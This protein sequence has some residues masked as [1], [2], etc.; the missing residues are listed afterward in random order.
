MQGA[1]ANFGIS[2]DQI[3][4]VINPQPVA[5]PQQSYSAPQIQQAYQDS[6]AQ[7]YTP[8]QISYG[9]QQNFGISPEQYQT[10]LSQPAISAAPANPYAFYDA[11]IKTD[12]GYR[13]SDLYGLE[14][15]PDQQRILGLSRFDPTTGQRQTTDAFYAGD[16]LRGLQQ[17]GLGL[18][19]LQGLNRSLDQTGLNYRP[20]QQYGA[21]GS[22]HGIDFDA[23]ARGQLGTAY[24]WTSDV[25]VGAKGPSALAQLQRDQQIAQQFG[26]QG[27]N[28]GLVGRTDIPQFDTRTL[29]GGV[30][31]VTNVN[32]GRLGIDPSAYIGQLGGGLSN[33]NPAWNGAQGLTTYGQP[34]ALPS[35]MRNSN[36][37][38]SNAQAVQGLLSD[39]KRNVSPQVSQTQQP[40]QSAQN[41]AFNLTDAQKSALAELGPSQ[42]YDQR[43]LQIA[44]LT[45]APAFDPSKASVRNVQ[46]SPPNN[47]TEGGSETL[48][49]PA[50]YSQT[51]KVGN[52]EFYAA[53]DQNG[54]LLGAAPRDSAGGGLKG[55]FTNILDT[56]GPAAQ[57]ALAALTAGAAAP[58]GGLL[59]LSGAAAGAAGGGLLG[60]G[61]AGLSGGNVLRGGLTG[62]IG[63][64]LGASDTFRA[65]SPI[66]RGAVAGAA[67]GGV[68]G[69]FDGN[70][71]GGALR[72]GLT[73]AAGAG[74]NQAFNSLAN[75]FSGGIDFNDIEP[76][77]FPTQE[78][79]TFNDTTD[80]LAF[81]P[82]NLRITAESIVNNPNS[83]PAQ[84]EQ[85]IADYERAVQLGNMA[86][87]FGAESAY[88]VNINGA[89]APDSSVLPM[90]SGGARPAVQP[91]L[92]VPGKQP[93]VVDING[94][95]NPDDITPIV[96]TA[97]SNDSRQVASVGGLLSDAPA[98]STGDGGLLSETPLS[99]IADQGEIA[100]DPVK[101]VIS[102]AVKNPNLNISD[103]IK[104]L[105][106]LGGG[107]A[108]IKG[109]SGGGGG[110]GGGSGGTSRQ[111]RYK[112]NPVVSQYPGDLAKYGE[113]DIGDFK[114]YR[115]GLL[116]D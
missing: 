24:D 32:Y 85:A 43:A 39:E 103:L 62:A 65:L 112:F 87:P 97:V 114:F 8:E 71:I 6:I 26:I 48:L 102:E 29:G 86:G 52:Q 20:N 109:L 115:P 3:N 28:T 41:P 57:V 30:G 84:I 89:N 81:T 51:Y 40:I 108:A 100:R 35:Y 44:Q 94:A 82:E 92:T 10:A 2:A 38:A 36:A 49:I 77:S 98:V 9:A 56:G 83:T 105:A 7:G 33:I 96:P 88:R 113:T 4:S 47:G 25:N 50:G 21:Q 110:S 107:A 76:N 80:Y 70:I 19:A 106:L 93:Y 99:P 61:V 5:S 73:G 90:I 16:I 54:N 95:E 59:G 72:G 23:L 63:G 31:G 75:G 14:L 42:G 34:S 101:E 104:L 15:H 37:G 13:L 68:N 58:L 78:G 111:T 46:Y 64:G 45:G 69:I 91:L 1:Q 18:E 74:V 53:Y 116:T 79:D 12:T 27:A 17:Q 11:P 22:N 66:T 67:G 60:A 55:L